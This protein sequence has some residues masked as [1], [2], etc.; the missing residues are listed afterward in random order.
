L[1]IGSEEPLRIDLEKL[2]KRISDPGISRDLREVGIDNAYD[3]LAN[4]LFD[5][6]V[7][8][9]IGAGLPLNTDD[10][11]IIEYMAPRALAQQTESRNV[12]YF[13]S[14]REEEFPDIVDLSS[15]SPSEAEEFE[16]LQA[17]YYAARGHLMEAHMRQFYGGGGALAEIAAAEGLV[18]PRSTASCYLAYIFQEAGRSSLRAGEV[19]QALVFLEQ[20]DLRRPDFP[21]IMS[22]L[23]LAL[24]RNGRKRRSL[25]LFEEVLKADAKQI[26][27][28]IHIADALM[29]RGEFARA[30]ELIEGCLELDP[31][32]AKCVASMERI[33]GLGFRP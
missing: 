27:P 5:Q 2:R 28:R 31:G 6:G 23:A 14:R 1:L 4:Y 7:I 33:G 30:R 24:L 10:Y 11:P 22:D 25:D 17:A 20:A 29:D 19:R 8:E 12:P 9:E 16:A 15:L 32:N 21:A 26:I 3:L 18:S 13:L